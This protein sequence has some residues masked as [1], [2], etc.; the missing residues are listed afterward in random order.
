MNQ[1]QAQ[2][3]YTYIRDKFGADQAK[4]AASIGLGLVLARKLPL[5]S[6]AAED[7]YAYYNSVVVHAVM[8]EA[9]S[10]NEACILDVDLVEMTAKAFYLMR[11]Y[12]AY[13]LVQ[14]PLQS[15]DSGHFLSQINGV[16]HLIDPDIFAFLEKHSTSMVLVVNRM[17]ESEVVIPV[18]L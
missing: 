3:V 11:Y 9:A 14:I 10:F 1:F 6:S 7:G 8:M 5:P 12:S 15:D 13:P 4:K 18:G 2:Q 16:G 17:R